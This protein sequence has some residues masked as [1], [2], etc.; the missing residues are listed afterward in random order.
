MKANGADVLTDSVVFDYWEGKAASGGDDP[1]VT[2]RDLHYRD[3]EIDAIR[4]RLGPEDRVLDIGCGNGFA[5]LEYAAHVREIIGVDFSPTMVQGAQRKLDASPAQVRE[6]TT[7]AVA[8]ARELPYADE[9]FSC[10]VMERCLINIPDRT[11]QIAAAAEAARVLRKGGVFLLAEVTL[12]GH[13]RVNHY[14]RL[15]GLDKL[16]VHWHNTYLD[17]PTFVRAVSRYLDL[18]DTI[19]FGMYGFLSK[20]VHPLLAHP[21]EPSFD[22]KMNELAA[23]IARKVPDFDGCTHQVI[24]VWRKK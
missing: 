6:K 16:K 18:E 10:V 3:L 15:F 2:I 9:T 13:E 11:Q 4:G 7:F 20:I 24:F 1:T 5:T 12:Q 22:G 19:R 8:D 17:E 21:R 23:H 14:R